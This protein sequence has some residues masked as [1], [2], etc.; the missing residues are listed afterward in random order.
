MHGYTVMSHNIFIIKNNSG[1]GVPVS[2][3][4][5][6]CIITIKLSQVDV[7]QYNHC[8][9]SGF[10]KCNFMSYFAGSLPAATPYTGQVPIWL[11][12]RLAKPSLAIRTSVN[13]PKWTPCVAGC[14]NCINCSGGGFYYVGVRD[15]VPFSNS[16]PF[17]F[18]LVFEQFIL[19]QSFLS[20]N[21]IRSNTNYARTHFYS[22]IMLY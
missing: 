17:P 18:F 8:M 20:A 15:V 10:Q 3:G 2:S 7:V 22:I 19:L 1:S 14:I 12:T 5:K 11:R 6:S 16:S 9:C 13:C 4:E 21:P